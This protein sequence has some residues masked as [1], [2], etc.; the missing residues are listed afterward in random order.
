MRKGV[1]FATVRSTMSRRELLEDYLDRTN[2]VEIPANR[3]QRGKVRY[4]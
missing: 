1:N 4:V 2:P 3:K